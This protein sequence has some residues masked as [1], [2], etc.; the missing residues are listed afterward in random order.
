MKKLFG[1]IMLGCLLSACGSSIQ[2]ASDRGELKLAGY[3]Q[4]DWVTRELTIPTEDGMLTIKCYIDEKAN[5]VCEGQ[6]ADGKV[7]SSEQLDAAMSVTFE[8]R[9]GFIADALIDGCESKTLLLNIDLK[10][11]FEMPNM[12]LCFYINSDTL[13]IACDDEIVSE[14]EANKRNSAYRN[15]LAANILKAKNEAL[16][17][18]ISFNPG[19]VSEESET[20]YIEQLSIAH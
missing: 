7:V 3:A 14:E 19:L 20:I 9:S 18:F 1:I 11:Q 17:Q 6:L 4:E 8:D 12:P 5:E 13:T 15:A 16:D 10:T 2:D